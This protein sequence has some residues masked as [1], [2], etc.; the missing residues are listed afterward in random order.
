[1]SAKGRRSPTHQCFCIP[2]P[3]RH[4]QAN[5]P[6]WADVGDSRAAPGPHY[7]CHSHCEKRWLAWGWEGFG[8]APGL[9][10]F[11]T[12]F[13]LALYQASPN[14]I[15][16]D[17]GKA[18]FFP[19]VASHPKPRVWLFPGILRQG[20][21]KHEISSKTFRIVGPTVEG[22]QESW[23]VGLAATQLPETGISSEFTG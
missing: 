8:S 17:L 6:P 3:T 16:G 22:L 19:C 18:S 21:R 12:T 1:M 2:L 10:E 11:P 20:C 9:N 13:C 5:P 7:R 23:G 4:Q 14:L 15:P